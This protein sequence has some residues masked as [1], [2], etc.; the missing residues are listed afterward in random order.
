MKGLVLSMVLLGAV[1]SQA[2]GLTLAEAIKSGY[3]VKAITVSNNL[4][5]QKGKSMA[6]CAGGLEPTVACK[7]IE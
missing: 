6:W 2:F 5:L 4:I 7:V 3:E 1:T